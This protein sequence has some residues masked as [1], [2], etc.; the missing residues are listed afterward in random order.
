MTSTATIP[1]VNYLR[2]EPEPH[3][4]A[5][6]CENCGASFFERRNAC[7]KCASD[8]FVERPVPT[9]GTI[10]TFTIVA[11]AAAGVPVPYVAAVVDCNGVRVKGNIV[12]CPPDPDHV[13]VGM[14]VRLTTLNVGTDAHGT[15]AI[16]FGFEPVTAI[17]EG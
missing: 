7:A 6:T 14:P 16:G 10:R 1:I 5:N 13:R 9:T 4:V 2:L 11:F 15:E 12:N 17:K 3:L 8:V